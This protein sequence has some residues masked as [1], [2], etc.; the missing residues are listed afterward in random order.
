VGL[1]FVH[2]VVSSFCVCVCPVLLLSLWQG[3]ACLML[4]L[5]YC[6]SLVCILLAD[7]SCTPYTI[8][9]ELDVFCDIG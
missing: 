2:A 7:P 6:E 8:Q 4:F 1:L 9:C 5:L 3:L